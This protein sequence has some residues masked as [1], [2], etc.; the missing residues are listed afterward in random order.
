MQLVC[1]NLDRS[2]AS[3]GLL[4]SFVRS[5]SLQ[6]YSCVI[7]SVQPVSSFGESL[8]ISLPWNISVIHHMV[9]VTLLSPPW[10]KIFARVRLSDF[11]FR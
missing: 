9:I 10:A 3:A 5:L 4:S 1:S 2:F 11:F 8:E 6:S 7:E